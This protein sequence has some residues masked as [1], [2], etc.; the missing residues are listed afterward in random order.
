MTLTTIDSA[1]EPEAAARA[2]HLGRLLEGLE[3]GP[4]RPGPY[5]TAD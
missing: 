4:R 2:R 5:P 1:V 3:Q